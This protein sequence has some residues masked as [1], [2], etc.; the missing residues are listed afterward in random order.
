MF[1]LPHIYF[2]FFLSNR[3]GQCLIHST[4]VVL[5]VIIS[6]G[7][8]CLHFFLN[9]HTQ[10]LGLESQETINFLL[11]R[12]LFSLFQVFFVFFFFFG[13]WEP[14]PVPKSFRKGNSS[15]LLYKQLLK[16]IVQATY[17]CTYPST[18]VRAALQL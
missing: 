6:R 4:G 1:P 9:I 7:K 12:M 18:G 3:V 15:L 10:D 2:S 17:L 13:T 14:P 16:N 5:M 8:I 11:V